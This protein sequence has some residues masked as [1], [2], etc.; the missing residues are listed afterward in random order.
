MPQGTGKTIA[1]LALAYEEMKN[2]GKKVIC[3][4]HLNFPYTQFSLEY[5]LEHISDNEMEN[6]VLLLDEAYQYMDS[7]MSQSKISRVFTYFIVQT[8]KRGVDLYICTHSLE[9]VDVRLRRAVDIRGVCSYSPEPVCL[10]CKGRKE[11]KNGEK[12]DRCNGLGYTGWGRVHF[13]RVRAPRGVKR[14]FVMEINCSKYFHLY[15]TR[16][17]M[18]ISQKTLSGIDTSEVV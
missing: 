9:N 15:N 12:C 4:N 1:A 5:F 7:R 14:R 17:R 13:L 11:I 10:K 6:A 2:N 18:P 8:R 3:N 16:E